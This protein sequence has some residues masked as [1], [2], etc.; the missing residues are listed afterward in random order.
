MT[1]ESR[2]VV[3]TKISRRRLQKDIVEIIKH[4]LT[5]I[6]IQRFLD[7]WKKVKDKQ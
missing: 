3:M 5:D 7:D 6:G 2:N 1:E 4:P